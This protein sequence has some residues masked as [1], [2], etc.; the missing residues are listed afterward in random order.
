MDMS[1][2][3]FRKIIYVDEKYT[4]YEIKYI[5]YFYKCVIVPPYNVLVCYSS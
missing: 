1:G 5:V 3:D 2:W 4:S